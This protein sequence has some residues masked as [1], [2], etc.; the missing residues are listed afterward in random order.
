TGNINV[1]REEHFRV[2]QDGA[3]LANSGH[4]DAELELAALERLAEGHIREVRQ[5]V[6][7]YDLGKKKLYLLAEGR[8]VNLGAAEGHPAAVMDMSFAGQALSVEFVAGNHA[9][10]GNTVHVVP[11]EIDAQIARLKLEARGIFLEGMTEEQIRYTNSWDQ[12]T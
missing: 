8:L 12:G 1:F 9:S 10:L 2:M 6:R 11:A 5:N 3:M 4:F 7:E